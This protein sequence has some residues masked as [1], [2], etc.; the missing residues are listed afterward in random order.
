MT[1]DAAWVAAE[2][3]KRE[4]MAA[5]SL[6]RPEDEHSSCGVG[7]VVAIDGTTDRPDGS[8]YHISW[9]LDPARGRRAVQS[10]EVIRRCGWVAL[11]QPVP[12]KLTPALL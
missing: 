1:T 4:R 11:D 5:T 9:S 3:A 8:T 12:V 6:W 2:E 7:L 10:N